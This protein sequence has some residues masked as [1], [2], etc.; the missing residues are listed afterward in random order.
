[1]FTHAIARLPG[2]DFANGITT[3]NLGKPDYELILTQ[4]QAYLAALQ[5]LG[6]TL[7][8][9]DPL[10]GFPDAYF[11]EDAAVVTPEVAI[12]TR[13]GAAARRGEEQTI[14][15]ALSKLLPIMPIV[16]P[17]TLEGGD[18][19]LAERHFYIG[20]SERTN[21][22]GARQLGTIMEKYGYTWTTI[23]VPEG[24]HLKSSVTY[25][26]NNTLVIAQSLLQHP[27]FSAYKKILVP[28]TEGYA[29]NTLLVNG[30]LIIP[31][32]FPQLQAKLLADG[33]DVLTL[34]VSEP[35][36]MDGALT[37]MS[38]RF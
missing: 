5:S 27:A 34:D 10:P 6:V 20:L 16:A 30:T 12:I 33:F 9:L 31:A 15:E 38:L 11:V 37:C 36:K 26:G 2:E 8:V 7:T 32:G 14:A 1:M 3:S 4:H 23:P 21:E 22:E 28:H 13:P 35:R 17:G 18:V 25:A 24:F 29:A 19:M